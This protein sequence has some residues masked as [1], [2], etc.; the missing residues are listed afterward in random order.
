VFVRFTSPNELL[1]L[2]VPAVLGK[3]NSDV[4]DFRFQACDLP[5]SLAFI[6]PQITASAF[7]P[8]QS[9]NHRPSPLARDADVTDD[10]DLPETSRSI[11]QTKKIRD[12]RKAQ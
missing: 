11:N 9:V 1:I 7:F 3:R 5:E 2:T 10:A 12:D 8:A 6:D 4:R